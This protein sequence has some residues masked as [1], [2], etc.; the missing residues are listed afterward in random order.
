MSRALVDI[1]VTAM[2]FSAGIVWTVARYSKRDRFAFCVVAVLSPLIAFISV[3]RLIFLVMTD[4]VKV[5]PCPAGLPEAEL[6]VAKEHQKM[7]GGEL[8][9]P[10]FSR[11]W[12][13]AYEL[14]LQ[15]EVEGIERMAQRFLVNA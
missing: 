13:R 3:F 12:Q 4:Q 1:T 2:L 10:T 7:F 15:R 6:L 14:E 8:R 9:E 11:N 5:G